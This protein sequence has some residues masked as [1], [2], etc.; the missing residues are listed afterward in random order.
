MAGRKKFRLHIKNNRAGEDVFRI[1][2]ARLGAAL[3]RRPDLAARLDCLIDW[4]L[5]RF[6]TSMATAEGLVT[7]DLP[8]RDLAARA[9]RLKWIHVIGAGVD[10]L[11]PLDW[12]P[13]GVA[14]SNNSGVHTA[15]FADYAAMALLLLNAGLPRLATAQRARRWDPLFSTPIAG[16]TVAVVGVGRM[17]GAV[18]RVA[19][20]LG[21][22]VLGVRRSGRPARHVDQMVRPERLGQVLARADFVVVTAPLTAATQGLIGPAEFARMKPSAGL[23]NVGRGPVVDVVALAAALRQGRLAGA[24]LDVFAAEPLPRSSPLWRVP[25]LVITPHV[26]SDDLEDYVSRTLDLVLDNAAR[27]LDGRR[28]RNRVRPKLGY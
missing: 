2:P 19:K 28:L 9:P 23:V 17:G 15:K 11:A 22:Q 25:N 14:L 8:T 18:A 3:K 27:L 1:T 5:D 26:S 24:V 13:P 4:D 6:W 7:W 21:L 10:H 12:L 20:R 16:K